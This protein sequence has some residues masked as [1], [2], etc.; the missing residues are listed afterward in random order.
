MSATGAA[1]NTGRRSKP[2]IPLEERINRL[3]E[4]DANGGCWL[5]FGAISLKG[6]GRI[7]VGGR[8]LTAHR[9]SYQLHCGEIPEGY[10]V[11][12]LCKVRCCVNPSHLEAV[13]PAENNARSNSRSAVNARRTHCAEG[14]ELAGGNLYVRKSGRR[15]C[16]ICMLRIIR[17]WK[18][19]RAARRRAERSEAAAPVPA[20]PG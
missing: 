11:D 2:S 16:R 6:Y 8:L 20:D 5:W 7:K 12:H 19:E 15:A 10:H 18:R 4:Y 17:D 14:H 9:W 1:P 3:V 13:S